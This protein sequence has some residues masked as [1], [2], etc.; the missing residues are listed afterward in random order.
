MKAFRKSVRR[1]FLANKGRFLGN[2]FVTLISLAITAGLGILPE[3]TKASYLT[4]FDISLVPDL[5]VKSKAK[6]GFSQEELDKIA[7][8]PGIEHNESFLTMDIPEGEEYYRFYLRDYSTAQVETLSLIEGTMPSKRGEVVVLEGNNVRPHHKVGEVLK[9]PSMELFSLGEVTITGIAIS[10]LYAHSGGNRANLEDQSKIVNLS[11]VF[12]ADS[13]FSYSFLN[14]WKSDVYLTVAGEHAYMTDPYKEAMNAKKAEVLA[15]LGENNVAVLTMEENE[16]Y[17]LYANYTE[18]IRL[19]SY[20]FPFFFILVCALVN[21]ITIHRLV[22]DERS[23]IAT[24]VSIGESKTRIVGKYILFSFL[25]MSLGALVGYFAGVL[26]L[27][28]V[29]YQAYIAVFR[30]GPLG[31][32]WFTWIGIFTYLALFVVSSA[33]TLFILFSYLSEKPADLMHDSAPKPGKKILLERIPFFWSHLSFSVKSMFRNLFRLKRNFILTFLSV[34]GST[35]LVFIGL[36]LINVSEALKTDELF[37]SV[38]SS[39]G[40]IS[41][42]IVLLALSMTVAVVYLLGNMNIQDR[43]REI[44]TLKVLGYSETKCCFYCFR[45]IIFTS[46]LASV[47]SLPFDALLA[48]IVFRFLGFGGIED[49]QWT[50]YVFSVVFV[51]LATIVVNLLLVHR[52]RRIDTTTSLKS[53]E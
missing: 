29:V 44:A 49:I 11:A 22:K 46:A 33:V 7:T 48:A 17:A 8:I 10:P 23:Q 15:A 51:V 36:S 50:S 31:M 34:A 38:A 30:L 12:Y 42:V 19:I 28:P 45:E 16:S 24:A 39:M 26:A 40:M 2:F 9:F 21:S 53:V 43:V 5:I 47:V 25:S 41:T 14:K 13:R 3:V 18:K 20:I 35:F 52:I 32:G 37:Q 1:S 6:T 4:N 27:P